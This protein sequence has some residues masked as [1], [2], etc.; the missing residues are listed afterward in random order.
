MERLMNRIVSNPNLIADDM[1]NGKI[2]RMFNN[3]L[4]Q[5]MVERTDIAQ[6]SAALELVSHFQVPSKSSPHV[7]PQLKPGQKQQDAELP[8]KQGESEGQ[9]QGQGK[10][11]GKTKPEPPDEELPRFGAKAKPGKAMAK[12]PSMEELQRL[13]EAEVVTP[14]K[15]GK[16]APAAQ[17]SADPKPSSKTEGKQAA[18]GA[19]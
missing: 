16:E 8:H 5:R 17:T 13:E 7:P 19:K 9:G 6:D 12:S 2:E 3:P 18:S 10:G 14:V 4:F 15:P 1:L 11:K